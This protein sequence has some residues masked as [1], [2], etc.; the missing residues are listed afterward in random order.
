MSAKAA[1]AKAVMKY[2]KTR[3]VK[4]AV[5]KAAKQSSKEKSAK[6]SSVSAK[7]SKLAVAKGFAS[8]AAKSGAN[9]IV[10]SKFKVAEAAFLARQTR[11]KRSREEV[12][13]DE[14]E[15]R[16]GYTEAEKKQRDRYKKTAMKPWRPPQK[17][18]EGTEDEDV[19]SS[20]PSSCWGCTQHYLAAVGFFCYIGAL[21][22]LAWLLFQFIFRGASMFTRR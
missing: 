4:E 9:A 5:K 8:G 12:L 10:G 22:F 21:I 15:G 19:F 13:R 20:D 16:G 7:S 3:A 6:S 11:G 18:G 2:A 17:S 1:A 14:E